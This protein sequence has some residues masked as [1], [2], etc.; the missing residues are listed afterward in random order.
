MLSM[1]TLRVAIVTMGSALLLGPGLAAAIDLD[2]DVSETNMA[3]TYALESLGGAADTP[4]VGVVRN[5]AMRITHYGLNDAANDFDIG[6]TSKI[7][8]PVG[9][10]VRLELGGGLVFLD[11]AITTPDG[12][13][14]AAFNA[15]PSLSIAGGD[16]VAIYRITTEVTADERISFALANELA[17]PAAAGA[18]TATMTA[19]ENFNDALAGVG[20]TSMDYFGGSATVVRVAS[21]LDASVTGGAAFT[22]AVDTGF[23]WF[24]NPDNPPGGDT[25]YRAGGLLGEFQAVA[26]P[27]GLAA[28]DGLPAEDTDIIAIGEMAVSVAIEGDL[29][30]G[31]FDVVGQM[32]DDNTT[33]DVNESEMLMACPPPSMMPIEDPMDYAMGNLANPDDA[34]AA[35][36]TIG[37]AS[38]EAGMYGL[39]VNVDVA[40]EETNMNAIPAGTYEA[41]VMVTGPGDDAEPAVAATG[42]IG[43]IRR[44]GASV[45]ISYL[46]TSEKH[47]QRLIITN[48]GP[49]PIMITDAVFQ[50]EDGTE[51]ELSA[52]AQAAAG[53]PAAMIQPGETAVHSVSQ[54]LSITGDSRRTAATLSFNANPGNVS[55]ATT[56]VNLSDSSTD[57]V[58]WV[59]K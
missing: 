53:T 6:V 31:A 17:V 33:P 15:S 36:T 43:T 46:T 10:F 51:V 26:N 27:M 24:H 57:T 35:V 50:S 13:G 42:T 38:G 9:W 2:M 52:L 54:M 20:E 25:P 55:V 40:G 5:A 32:M 22:A 34:E 45:E 4:G 47:N 11:G 56:Q 7:E 44:D 14:S 8:I 59:V 3:P 1:K 41:T 39:C 49:R 19:H 37:V 58:M 23:R 21:G 18:Y 48:R 28:N 30:I 12:D 29:T 16:S